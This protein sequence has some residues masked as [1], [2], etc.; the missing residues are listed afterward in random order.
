VHGFESGYQILKQSSKIPAGTH[1]WNFRA[2][3][4]CVGGNEI[5]LEAHLSSPLISPLVCDR[6]LASL[7]L[8][9]RVN[10]KIQFGSFHFRQFQPAIVFPPDIFKETAESG[11]SRNTFGSFNFRQFPLV[12][13]HPTYLKRKLPSVETHERISAVSA[14]GSFH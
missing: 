3:L 7:I 6:V 8:L 10:R 4:E 5:H 14:F 9:K 12:V 13:F 2:T 11:N 1:F